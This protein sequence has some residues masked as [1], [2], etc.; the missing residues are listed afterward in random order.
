MAL[1]SNLLTPRFC[2]LLW[3]EVERLPRK[4]SLRLVFVLQRVSQSCFP[5][6]FIH[7]RNGSFGRDYFRLLKGA[8]EKDNAHIVVLK[9]MIGLFDAVHNDGRLLFQNKSISGGKQ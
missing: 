3:L 5:I 1:L 9:R 7:R 6:L 2:K 8:D 4:T